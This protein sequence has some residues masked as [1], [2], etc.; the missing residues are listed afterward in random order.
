MLPIK[1]KAGRVTYDEETNSCTPSP[2][3][4]E[5][6]IKESEEGPGFYSFAWQSRDKTAGSN[7]TAED[8]LL[9]AGDVTWK[10]V[11][12]CKTG[13]VYMLTFLS[14]GA[15]HLFW[16]QNVSEDEDDLSKDTDK[17]IKINESIHQILDE[18]L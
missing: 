5:I 3:K 17:D 8:F 18:E 1:F 6:T 14:S 9:I 4:G 10:K 2:I 16:M 11:K 12:S 13:R 7:N 15:K